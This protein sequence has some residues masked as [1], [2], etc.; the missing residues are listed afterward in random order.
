MVF[1]PYCCLLVEIKLNWLIMYGYCIFSSSE[2]WSM[3]T[4]NPLVMYEVDTTLIIPISDGMLIVC[5]G[6]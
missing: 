1:L 4:R 3:P 5:V 2:A 6:N